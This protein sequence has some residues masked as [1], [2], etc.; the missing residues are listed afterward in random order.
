MAETEHPPESPE[1]A[2]TPCTKGAAKEYA[3]EQ[4]TVVWDPTLCIHTGACLRAAPDVFELG[5]RPWVRPDAA[6][7]EQVAAAIR[8]CP[9]SA[10]RYRSPSA[11]PELP[12]GPTTVEVRTN[13]PLFVRG[14]VRV[15]TPRGG[16][17]ADLTRAALC[18]CG[19]SANKPFCDNS[20]R[21]IEFRG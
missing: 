19:A 3:G 2:G 15:T 13:G 16:V 18:R 7:A 21:R 17:V 6:N 20:H 5:R 9:T 1:D 4:I 8:K 11:E 14:R 12:D 10:L